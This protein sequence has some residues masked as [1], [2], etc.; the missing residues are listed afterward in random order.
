MMYTPAASVVLMVVIT[1]SN[2][3][4]VDADSGRGGD[5][6]DHYQQWR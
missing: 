6:G 2:G 1:V 3:D 4:D 5:E